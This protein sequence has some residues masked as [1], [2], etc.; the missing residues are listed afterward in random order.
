MP[1]RSP[2]LIST[3][4]NFVGEGR[5]APS[6]N[7]ANL[8]LS[9]SPISL[10]GG[11]STVVVDAEREGDGAKVH[12]NTFVLRMPAKQSFRLHDR[13]GKSIFQ[14]KL[15]GKNFGK[16]TEGGY[17]M[18]YREMISNGIL[19]DNSHNYVNSH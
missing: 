9:C 16:V 8:T 17:Q 15:L 5:G 18:S 4:I 6:G 7:M 1:F 10:N 19:C 2:T 11:Q 13:P 14:P 12:S 3:N